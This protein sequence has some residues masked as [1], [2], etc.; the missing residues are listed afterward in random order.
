MNTSSYSDK[1]LWVDLQAELILPTLTGGHVNRIFVFKCDSLFSKQKQGH[2]FNSF[3]FF[4]PFFF[5]IFLTDSI[6]PKY[7]KDTDGFLRASLRGNSIFAMQSDTLF[8]KFLKG[9]KILTKFFL[10]YLPT[11]AQPGRLI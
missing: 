5:F 2:T 10:S 4:L 7:F 3:M 8:S 6:N 11:H 1:L 9:I